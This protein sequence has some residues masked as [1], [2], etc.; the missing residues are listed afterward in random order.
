MLEENY[1]S[2]DIYLTLLMTTNIQIK[3]AAMR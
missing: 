1:I 3:T 2:T